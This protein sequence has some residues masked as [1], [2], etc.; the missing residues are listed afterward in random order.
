MADRRISI[1]RLTNLP[2]HVGERVSQGSESIFNLSIYAFGMAGVWIALGSVVLQFK[3]I[4]I[5]EAGPQ[6][7]LGLELD[8]NALIALISLA[9]L[10]VVAVVQPL[11]GLVSDNLASTN[12]GRS[13]RLPFVAVGLTGMCIATLLLGWATSFVV[14]LGVTLLIQLT[15]NIAQGPANAL[16]VDHVPPRERGRASG[17]LNLMRL[18]GAGLVGVVVV[19]IMSLY[20]P[21][22]APQWMWFAVVVMAGTL[23]AT[24]VYTLVALR[25]SPE[26]P[27]E[28]VT[29]LGVPNVSQLPESQPEPTSGGMTDDA[30]DARRGDRRLFY[31][32]LGAMA[33]MLA[34]QSSV[35]IN[36]LFFL[37]DVIGLENPAQGA[38]VIIVAIVVGAALTAYPSG[39]LSDR[40]GRGVLLLAS[41]IVGAAGMAMLMLFHSLQT[42]VIPAAVIGM[43]VG[44]N[45]SVG[46]ALANDLVRRS[47]AARDLGLLGIASL[48]GA[49]IGRTSG[50]G[51]GAMN[52]WGDDIG[53]DFLGYNVLVSSAAVG[54]LASGVML[55]LIFGRRG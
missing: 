19:Q 46:L 37:Q 18:L 7:V 3:V 2:A 24:S 38:N 25:N 43:S 54:L 12:A 35:Q 33:L 1:L 16:I 9:G 15:G 31:G 26:Y 52:R 4:N 14:I 41:G 8:K 34:A 40:I 36:A 22:D 20:D 30:A 45:L 6:T 29:E 11:A 17:M 32:F 55:Y 53:I 42:L 50:F 39:K 5:V 44:L 27:G 13:K 51:I 23:A 49:V 48:F 10:A 28:H 47:T 21:L